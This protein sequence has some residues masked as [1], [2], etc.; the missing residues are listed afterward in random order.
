MY[1]LHT[2]E[3]IVKKVK[4]TYI[5]IKTTVLRRFT[6]NIKIGIRDGEKTKICK[7]DNKTSFD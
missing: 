5:I 7:F 2:E 6:Q 3:E 1:I 4:K